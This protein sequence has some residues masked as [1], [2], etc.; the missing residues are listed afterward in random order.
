[1]SQATE[2]VLA[3][4]AHFPA[5]RAWWILFAIASLLTL[6]LLVSVAAVFWR[7][8]GIWGNNIPVAWG[9]PI[10]NYIWWLGIG[11]AGTL[12]SAMLLLLN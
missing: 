6:L 10:S 4:P 12:I 11:H 1:M 2:R 5:K 7:G 8:T 9:F 3:T